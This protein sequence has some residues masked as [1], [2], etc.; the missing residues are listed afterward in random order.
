MHIKKQLSEKIHGYQIVSPVINII[1]SLLLNII[2]MFVSMNI[3]GVKYEMNDDLVLA[4]SIANGYIEYPYVNI[5]ITKILGFIQNLI[6]PLSAYGI[7]AE[8]LSLLSITTITVIFI[9]KFGMKIGTAFV[10]LINGF[11]GVGYFLTVSFTRQAAVLTVSGIMAIIHYTRKEKWVLGTT[12]GCF[13]SI[14]GG[15]YRNTVFLSVFVMAMALVGTISICDYIDL[16]KKR[17][18]FVDFLKV[19]FEPK[20]FVCAI[21][22]VVVALS[23]KALQKDVMHSTEE[24]SNFVEYTT[25]RS[26]VWDYGI[27]TYEECKDEYDAI[28]V[29]ENDLD[30]LKIG[31]VDGEKGLTLEKLNG[32]KSIANKNSN[33]NPITVLF[34]AVI[35]E[36]KALYPFTIESYTIMGLVLVFFLY[37]FL[38][39]K[40]KIFPPVL[41]GLGVTLCYFYIWYGGRIKFRGLFGFLLFGMVS[42]LY[43]I[44]REKVIKRFEK[45]QLAKSICLVLS[46]VIAC[47]AFA[48]IKKKNMDIVYSF[49]KK[50][51]VEMV[52]EFKT[53]EDSTY[54]IFVG[55]FITWSGDIDVRDVFHVS[56]L[57]K[58][59]NYIC[60]THVYYRSP[61]YNKNTSDFGIE[62]YYANLLNDGVYAV[63]PSFEPY[64]NVDKCM[65][66]YLQE[67]YSEG[68]EVSAQIV[69]EYT[70]YKVIK[71]SLNS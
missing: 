68:R 46:V 29:S 21:L 12:W 15:L 18:K 22:I 40:M 45:E 35:D 23:A 31:L 34:K 1:Y 4:Q 33:N 70:D 69:K 28:G 59:I 6:Y 42:I 16:E 66:K 5:I 25:V 14:I 2:I 41:I 37:Y 63:F 26:Q 13:L 61:F 27:P 32:I 7:A 67:H 39:T 8:V 65:K 38:Q 3:F 50:E 55:E 9:E 19:L 52:N 17:K 44:D 30:F 43:L 20:R 53:D 48:N 24:L 64:E 49:P 11:F 36:A 10:L 51:M 57:D 60:Q 56:K 47:T 71:Y 54:E 58:K 62:N